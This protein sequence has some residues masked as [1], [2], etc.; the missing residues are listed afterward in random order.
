MATTPVPEAGISLFDAAYR[1]TTMS[2]ECR[3]CGDKNAPWEGTLCRP[4]FFEGQNRTAVSGSFSCTVCGSDEAPWQGA[5]CRPCYS[6]SRDRPDEKY[7]CSECGARD[8][9]W[10]GAKCLVCYRKASPQSEIVNELNAVLSRS[11]SND[12]KAPARC[13]GC[14]RHEVSWPET[15]CENC[16]VSSSGAENEGPFP[17]DL[18][19]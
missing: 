9:P 11:S 7:E 8:A 18:P 14:G 1:S 2:F 6:E 13:Q 17:D 16:R 5:K 3:E 15:Q 19:F 10:A 12:R 4:C